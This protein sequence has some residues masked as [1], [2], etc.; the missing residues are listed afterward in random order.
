MPFSPLS[1]LAPINI[2]SSFTWLCNQHD[3]T[4]GYHQYINSAH[5]YIIKRPA[6]LPLLYN[7]QTTHLQIPPQLYLLLNSTSST[8]LPPQ[9]LNSTSPTLLHPQLLHSTSL[10]MSNHRSAT[11][12]PRETER[13]TDEGPVPEIKRL[14][15]NDPSTPSSSQRRKSNTTVSTPAPAS[16]DANEDM[17]VYHLIRTAGQGTKPDVYENFPASGIGAAKYTGTRPP[18]QPDTARMWREWGEAIFGEHASVQGS[19]LARSNTAI[20]NFFTF[21]ADSNNKPKNE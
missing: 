16:D 11:K 6:I 4:Q 13:S 20:N 8:L 2:Y 19:F 15:I 17:Y 9:L 14:R 21:T 5:P 7:S 10:K 12:R 3:P 1:P 18:R